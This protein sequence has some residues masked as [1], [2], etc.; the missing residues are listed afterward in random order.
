M[1][2]DAE[3]KKL[4]ESLAALRRLVWIKPE[5]IEAFFCGLLGQLPVAPLDDDADLLRVLAWKLGRDV[6]RASR[7]LALALA[8]AAIAE[9]ISRAAGGDSD[10]RKS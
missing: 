5:H 2:D 3:T 9:I 7:S 6:G 1:S 10:R 8:H 4:F